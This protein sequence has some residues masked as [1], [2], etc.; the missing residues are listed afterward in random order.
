MSATESFYAKLKAM[1]LQSSFSIGSALATGI[2]TAAVLFI[3]VRTIQAGLMTV[4]DL[5]IVMTYLGL[6]YSPLK[7]IGQKVVS[8]QSASASAERA[9]SLMDERPDVPE[10]PDAVS[11][12]K[13]RGQIEFRDVSFAYTPEEPILGHVNLT[14]PAGCR[15]GIIGKTGAGNR[16]CLAC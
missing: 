9:F 3:G 4:G 2:G 11:L 12:T 10:K 1:L 13:A 7:T 5:L 15:V 14:I 8:L 6:L 16:R